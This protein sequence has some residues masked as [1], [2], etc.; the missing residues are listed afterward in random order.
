MG[1]KPNAAGPSRPLSPHLTIYSWPVTM[2]TSIVHRA[3]GMALAAGTL[4]FAWWVIAAA[5]GPEAYA[6]F[7]SI[8]NTPLGQFVLF[9]FVWSL[10][11]HLLNGLRHLA[12]D[13][14]YGF[15]IK[16]ASATGIL[17]FVLSVVVAVLIFLA[18]YHAKGGI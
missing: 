13:I 11:Y 5:T 3:T 10:S 7:Q 17:V 6:T 4:V 2:A 8:A 16:T 15:N 1:D 12:W 18:A 9:G 14:G